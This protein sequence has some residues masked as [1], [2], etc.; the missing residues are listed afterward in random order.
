MK[1]V[2]IIISVGIALTIGVLIFLGFYQPNVPVGILVTPS[3]EAP[4]PEP[5]PSPTPEIKILEDVDSSNFLY[6]EFHSLLDVMT[7][8]QYNYV[9]SSSTDFFNSVYQTNV[10]NYSFDQYKLQYDNMLSMRFFYGNDDD[11]L[12]PFNKFQGIYSSDALE[13]IFI[14]DQESITITDTQYKYSADLYVDKEII[15]RFDF[16]VKK[17][18]LELKIQ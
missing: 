4:T 12:I 1:R 3:P 16:I 13:Y 11:L 15:E 2:L 6:L 8:S 10:R 14:L 18:T 7:T 17:N 9:M 5:T